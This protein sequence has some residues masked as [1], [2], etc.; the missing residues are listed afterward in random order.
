ML[1]QEDQLGP[2]LLIQKLLLRR[3]NDLKGILGPRV[4]ALVWV[5]HERHLEDREQRELLAGA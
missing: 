5:D 4:L 3:T 1:Q 2:L